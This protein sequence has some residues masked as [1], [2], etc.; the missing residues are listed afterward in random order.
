MMNAVFWDVTPCGSC[1]NRPNFLSRHVLQVLVTANVVPSSLIVY[2]LMMVVIHFSETSVVTRS[3]LRHIS[4]YSTL[5]QPT[6][7]KARDDSSLLET[8]I[9]LLPTSWREAEFYAPCEYGLHSVSVH[10][11]SPLATT[12]A[13]DRV[14]KDGGGIRPLEQN[15]SERP[16]SGFHQVKLYPHWPRVVCC[17][18]DIPQVSP[19]EWQFQGC[20][21]AG[22]YFVLAIVSV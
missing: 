7:P 11:H 16:V 5:L 21:T 17:Q 18:P 10:G 9:F 14:D 12:P 6:S 15:S 8:E 4:A 19:P 1:K 3:T 22:D 13:P 20:F 2:T